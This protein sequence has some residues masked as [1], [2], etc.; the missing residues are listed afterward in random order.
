MGTQW[1]PYYNVMGIADIFNS[2]KVFSNS[3]I[4]L[5]NTFGTRMDNSLIYTTPNWSGFSGQ[6]MLV[7]NGQCP[8]TDPLLSSQLR[9][10]TASGLCAE[11][12]VGGETN[13]VPANTSDDI[14][15]W[16]ISLSY[17]NGPWFVGGTYMGLE[18]NDFDTTR[19][20]LLTSP[21]TRPN[22]SGDQYGLAFGYN[23]GPFAVTLNW[24]SGDVNNVF[25]GDSDNIYV[26]GQY[27]FGN[28]VIRGAY[29][30]MTPDDGNVRVAGVLRP[31]QVEFITQDDINNWVLGYQYNFSKRTRVWVEYIG[32][33]VDSDAIGA[34]QT[35]SIGTRVDF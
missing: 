3:T 22:W 18:G 6:A 31:G 17:K 5:G 7:I 20:L 26:T 35:V 4:Y 24:E 9:Y 30:Y 13:L 14:D 32:Q 21:T 2:S 25:W 8:P 16:G 15:L 33:D 12:A 1:T 34:R 11:R 19:D 29:G 23:S 28:N 27:T 10:R